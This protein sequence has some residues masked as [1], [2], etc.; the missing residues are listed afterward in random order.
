MQR[1]MAAKGLMA[2]HLA[3]RASVSRSTVTRFFDGSFQ[4]PKT[5]KKLAQALGYPL[6]RYL[7]HAERASA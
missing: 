3:L 7:L 4:T 5:A 2:A 6:R 1:D